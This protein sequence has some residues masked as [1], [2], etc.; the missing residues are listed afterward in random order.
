MTSNLAGFSAREFRDVLGHFPTGVAVITSTAGESGPVG[1]VVGSFTSVSLEPPLVAFMPA[2]TSSTFPKIQQSG[3][4][5]VNVLSADQ[6]DVCRTFA[7]SGGPKFDGTRYTLSEGGNPILDGAVA[8]IDCEI[9]S[10]IEAGDHLICL[11]RVSSLGTHDGSS[12]L[13][14]FKGGYGRFGAASLAAPAEEDLISHLLLVDL[15]RPEMERLSQ[16][17]GGECLASAVVHEEL[18]IMAVAG[19]SPPGQPGTRVGQRIPL[20]A[21]VAPLFIAF[22]TQEGQETWLERM[23]RLSAENREQYRKALAAARD[24]GYAFGTRTGPR[25]DLF[26]ALAEL[27]VDEPRAAERQMVREAVERLADSY[28]P[29]DLSGSH[30]VEYVGAPIF[31]KTG[32]MVLQ[33]TV[34]GLPQVD[35]AAATKISRELLESCDRITQALGGERPFSAK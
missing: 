29:A 7:R 27:H 8:W 5:C 2:K 10:V 33:L 22:G 24:R 32:R 6:E 28:D 25:R 13:L 23:P 15:A 12:P 30:G 20:V 1:L 19:T 9:E 35:A 18:V 17:A 16:L 3:R 11:G 14:F 34:F 4:F 21:P 26:R 31:D